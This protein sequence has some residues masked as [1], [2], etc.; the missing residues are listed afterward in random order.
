MT[1]GSRGYTA[2][3]GTPSNSSPIAIIAADEL[4][5]V[6]ASTWTFVAVAA[7]VGWG[8]ASTIELFQLK[9]RG[10]VTHDLQGFLDMLGQLQW[11]ALVAAAVIGAPMLLEDARRGALELYLSRPVNRLQHLAGK[12]IA[13]FAVS[14]TIF[15]IPILLYTVG[16]YVFFDQ[17]PAGWAAA[18]W[19]ALPYALL[20]SVTVCGLALGVSCLAR[21]GRAAALLL[22]G[23]A[24]TLHV[25]ATSLLP[26][27]TEAT[28]PA[29]LSPF[30][31]MQST[32]AWLW[33]SVSA[34]EFPAWWGLLEVLA[35]AA[36]GWGLVARFHP[37][38]RGE[39]ND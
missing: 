38:L 6:R 5:R 31:A 35:L 15:A 1:E 18:P 14:L 26:D 28:W 37:R 11:F 27:L 25:I 19:T 7:G 20:W 34:G 16:T 29:I 4:R 36:V 13:L 22:I 9:Q 17:Q 3:V 2:W 12:A 10:D 39:G 21:S 30:N 32:Q 33:P 24:V 8:L 23:G